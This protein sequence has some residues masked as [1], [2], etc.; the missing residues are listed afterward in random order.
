M[1]WPADIVDA[2]GAALDIVPAEGLSV[3]DVIQELLDQTARRAVWRMRKHDTD[4][5]SAL[6][7]PYTPLGSVI[8]DA[9]S[10]LVQRLT[11]K[12]P[13]WGVAVEAL[14]TYIE[15]HIPDIIEA[16]QFEAQPYDDLV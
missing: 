9:V 1:Y 8:G 15:D 6:R 4:V 14:H 11:L 16:C 3:D 13:L 10:G 2:F 12:G 7:S 5:H